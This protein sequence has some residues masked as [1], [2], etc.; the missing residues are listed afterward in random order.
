LFDA[1]KNVEESKL[2]IET[3]SLSN[4]DAIMTRDLDYKEDINNN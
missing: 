3:S 1:K 4:N 2:V